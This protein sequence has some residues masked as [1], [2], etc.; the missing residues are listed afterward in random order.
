MMKEGNKMGNITFKTTL[1]EQIQ[2]RLDYE[3]GI[4]ALKRF[5]ENPVIHSI[6]EV[7]KE[8][9]VGHRKEIYKR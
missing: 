9:D 2:D 7:I 5:K 6:D 8:L 4:Q 1:G 3:A